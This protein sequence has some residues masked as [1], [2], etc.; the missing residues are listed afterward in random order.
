MDRNRRIA[1]AAASALALAVPDTLWAQ[2]GADD[3]TWRV[4]VYGWLPDIEAKTRFPTGGDGP[5]IEV[6]ASTL[7]DN[8]EFTLQAALYA[9]RGSWGLFTDLMYVNV[10][11]SRSGVRDPALGPA[12][13]PAEVSYDVDYDMKSWVWTLAGAYELF[14]SGSGVTDLIFGARMLDMKQ[15]LAWTA[16]RQVGSIEPP[17]RDGSAEVKMTLWDAV[18][19]VKGYARFGSSKR[20]LVPYELDVGS[21]DSDL[22]VQALLGVG[23]SFSWGELIATYRYMDYDLD[24][25]GLVSDLNFS[26]P[27]VGVSFAW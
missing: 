13:L 24:D 3:W 23:Y 1:M 4:T 19:G 21:G 25:D 26:G 17:A 14:A 8:L 16:Q 15:T 20:W 9:K 6:D 5:D 10:G 2:D 11:A 7:L 18:V 12:Q 22:T 27:M